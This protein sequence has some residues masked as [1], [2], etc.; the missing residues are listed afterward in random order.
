MSIDI[1]RAAVL[2]SVAL[3]GVAGGCYGNEASAFPPG[4][5]PWEENVA[6]MP[7][8]TADDPCP[9]V[10]VFSADATFNGTQE[11]GRPYDAN[12]L[13]ARACI[14]QPPAVVWAALQDPQV[15]RDHT[16]VN[17]FEVIDPPMPEECDGLY[18][19]QINAGSPFSVDFRLCWRMGVAEGTDDM[20][21]VTA[22]RWQKVWGSTALSVMEGSIIT[23][24]LEA[25][26]N[27]T[28]IE[29]QYH[30][31]ALT[32]TH[33]TIRD[34]LTVV[35]GRLRERAHDRPLP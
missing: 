20:P 9:E 24:S 22:A 35:Y 8:P 3:I 7:T 29:Y 19:S 10:I 1:S 6:A 18:Q 4:L 28:V 26:P 12:S 15:G 25:D 14:H 27:I 32:S 17:T 21:L 11:S 31:N 23:R 2:S 13:H 16:T 30:L 33:Q 5:E 34:Y